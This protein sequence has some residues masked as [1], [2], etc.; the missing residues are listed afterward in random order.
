MDRLV[1]ISNADKETM[2]FSDYFIEYIK[3]ANKDDQVFLV[4]ELVYIYY[5]VTPICTNY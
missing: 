4:E 1:S 5:L 2:F 3:N